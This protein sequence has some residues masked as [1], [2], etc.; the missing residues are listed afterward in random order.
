MRFN[1]MV[2]AGGGMKSIAFV[3]ALCVLQTSMDF[4]SPV[5]SQNGVYSFCGTSAGA[6][7][8]AL[9]YIRADFQSTSTMQMIEE[10]VGLCTVF[11]QIPFFG[12]TKSM[13]LHTG[14][15]ILALFRRVIHRLTSGELDDPTF[16]ELKN[17]VQRDGPD[18]LVV[19]ATNVNTSEATYFS[20]RL[21]PDVKVTRALLASMCLPLLFD[22]ITIDGESFVDGGLSD[23][24][25]FAYDVFNMLNTLGSMERRH[26][27]HQPF[28]CLNFVFTQEKRGK[29]SLSNIFTA[30][31]SGSVNFYN[32]QLHMIKVLN[33]VLPGFYFDIHFVTFPANCSAFSFSRSKVNALLNDGEIAAKQ[34][35]KARD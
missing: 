27:P 10:L 26:Q 5:R 17:F 35:L 33:R 7:I 1:R 24:C 3:G 30:L 9:C 19:C 25:P 15:S 6:L 4:R 20:A 12:Q 22:P 2:F 11:D 34:Y 14:Q 13:S 16:V 32:Y 31:V 23:N 18:E 28:R 29:L 21:T 8:A